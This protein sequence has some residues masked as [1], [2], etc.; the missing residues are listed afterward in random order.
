MLN[1]DLITIY[2]TQLYDSLCFFHAVEQVNNGEHVKN[3]IIEDD[4]EKSLKYSCERCK[5]EY[6]WDKGKASKCPVIWTKQ[7]I[8]NYTG[9]PLKV[10]K[11]KKEKTI[12]YH[13]SY[14]GYYISDSPEQNDKHS[15]WDLKDTFELI[16]S[17]HYE[18]AVPIIPDLKKQETVEE[19]IQQYV[20]DIS[21]MKG[22]KNEKTR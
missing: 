17:L 14:G 16:E 6:H 20:D 4:P 19:T 13:K 21:L 11:G 18:K 2:S 10:V 8:V 1:L 15:H 9:K 12:Y 3:E 5:E 7:M 22:K